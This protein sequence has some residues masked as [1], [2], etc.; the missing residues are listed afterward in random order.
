L[1]KTDEEKKQDENDNVDEAIEEQEYDKLKVKELKDRLK[2][3]QQDHKGKKVDLIERLKKTESWLC[4]TGRSTLH[5]EHA[6]KEELQGLR[7][8]Y[9]RRFKR[10]EIDSEN[11]QKQA[12]ETAMRYENL[13]ERVAE[14]ESKSVV[15]RNKWNASEKKLRL[16]SAAWDSE[17]EKR[18]QQSVKEKS[19]WA[20]RVRKKNT[21]VQSLTKEN[22]R[23]EQQV[24]TWI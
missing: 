7:D 20:K 14:I 23:L 11:A 8:G 2:K 17:R 1:E 12:A 15:L 5:I 16:R 10:L 22:K 13:K 4:K 18:V 24:R 19:D 6:Y 3:R 21:I 9:R